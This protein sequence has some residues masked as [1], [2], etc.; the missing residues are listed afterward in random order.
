M[1]KNNQDTPSGCCSV[2]CPQSHHAAYSRS[3]CFSRRS[4]I[5]VPSHFVHQSPTII[6]SQDHF[7]LT[8]IA[9]I[10][11]LG[12]FIATFTDGH[13][14]ESSLNRSLETCQP[15]MKTKAATTIWHKTCPSCLTFTQ[16]LPRIR[17]IIPS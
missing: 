1:F 7:L 13:W 17:T 3:D 16:F 10:N 6:I 12:V 4:S 15:K 9:L 5:A 8:K 11:D 2:P 14:P